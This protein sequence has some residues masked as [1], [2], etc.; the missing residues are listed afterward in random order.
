M[1]NRLHSSVA[2]GATFYGGEVER[3]RANTSPEVN[4]RIDREIEDRIHFY[5]EQDRREI[6]R[7]IEELEREWS[8]ERALEVEASAMGLTGLTL[9]LTV[10]RKFLALPA[11]VAG[12]MLLHGGQ[13]WYPLLPVFRRLGFRTRQEIDRE[14]FALKA[15]RGDFEGISSDSSAA[16]TQNAWQAVCA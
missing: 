6:S 16:K 14:K 3:V 11:F 8:I 10:N 13:G 15:L 12:M 4:A 1:D 7:R 5:A 2:N 9:G